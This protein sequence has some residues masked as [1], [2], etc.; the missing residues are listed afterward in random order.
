V[1][2]S[3]RFHNGFNVDENKKMLFVAD[4]NT[5]PFKVFFMDYQKVLN[6]EIYE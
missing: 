2:F 1:G 4:Y 3:H 6:V 5:T